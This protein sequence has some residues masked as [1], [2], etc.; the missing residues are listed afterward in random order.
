MAYLTLQTSL[1]PKQKSHIEKIVKAANTLLEIINDVLDFS[2]IE[3]GKLDIENIDFDLHEVVESVC[4]IVELKAYEKNLE[5]SVGH[6]IGPVF[7]GLRQQF[8]HRRQPHNDSCPL[9]F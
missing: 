3:A 7:G 6:S 9:R 8:R 4:S 2:K 5:F 1:E